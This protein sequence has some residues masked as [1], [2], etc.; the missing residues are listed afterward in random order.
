MSNRKAA[1]TVRVD[2]ILF[3][4]IRVIAEKER[5]SLNSQMERAFEETVIAYEKLN[6]E[7]ILDDE[8]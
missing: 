1:T 4:K 5:R 7:I 2:E 8:L 6:G 3:A